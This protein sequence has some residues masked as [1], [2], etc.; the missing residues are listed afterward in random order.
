MKTVSRV[1]GLVLEY[2]PS[3]KEGWVESEWRIVIK[4]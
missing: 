2:L 1:F 4:Q 3:G